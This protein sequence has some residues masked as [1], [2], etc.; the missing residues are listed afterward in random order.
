[1]VVV[2]I[3]IHQ[4]DVISVISVTNWIHLSDV[5]HVI[6]VISVMNVINAG[7]LRKRP[8]RSAEG[9]VCH[10]VDHNVRGDL[11]TG[12]PHPMSRFSLRNGE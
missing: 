1:M 9:V 8:A 6:S 4:V 3:N 2:L 12:Y 11:G 10:S 5:T 7:F